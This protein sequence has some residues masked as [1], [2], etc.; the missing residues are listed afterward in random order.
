MVLAKRSTQRRPSTGA[1]PAWAK[2]NKDVSEENGPRATGD[3]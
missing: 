1:T 2:R 3:E